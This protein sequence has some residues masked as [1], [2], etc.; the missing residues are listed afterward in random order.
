MK[1]AGKHYGGHSQLRLVPRRHRLL[2]ALP[3][4]VG[5]LMLL[6]LVLPFDNNVSRV[7][8][9]C[10]WLVAPVTFFAIY[11]LPLPRRSSGAFLHGTG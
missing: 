7:P 6:W 4:V 2:D 5:L 1:A 8:F 3:V 9:L 10:W 11:S